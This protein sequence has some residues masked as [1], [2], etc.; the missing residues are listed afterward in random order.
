VRR[1]LVALS[2]GL[3]I[4]A[5]TTVC[6]IESGFPEQRLRKVLDSSARCQSHDKLDNLYRVALTH[7][8]DSYQADELETVHSILGAIVV[9]REQLTDQQLSRLLDLELSMVQ[10]VLSRLQ[11]L[12]QGGHSRPIQVLHTSFTD[13][14]CD[15]ERCQDV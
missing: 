11:P 3:F 1:R 12:L 14:L 13:F 2:G 10:Q 6:F 7:P 9:A 8:F 5:S 15:P 4:W